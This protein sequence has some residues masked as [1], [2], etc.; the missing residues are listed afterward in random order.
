MSRDIGSYGKAFVGGIIAVFVGIILAVALFPGIA[1]GVNSL[2]S[3][4]TPSI[5]GTPASLLGN[6][7]LFIALGVML[8][9]V[10]FAL[11][12]LHGKGVFAYNY[13]DNATHSMKV[14]SIRSKLR[15]NTLF[16]TPKNST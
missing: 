15:L 7:V 9:A 12:F 1:T 11:S 16:I 5:T 4:A 3:G 14:T 13:A 6:V 2:T 8:F 10:G